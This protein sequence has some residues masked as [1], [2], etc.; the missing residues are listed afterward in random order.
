MSFRRIITGLVLSLGLIAACGIAA[1]A[2]VEGQGKGERHHDRVPLW[3]IIQQ[4]NLTDAQ[5]QQARA[6]VEKFQTNIEAQRQALT[7]L[8]RQKEQGTLS[9]DQRAQAQTLRGQ[10]DEARK[11]MQT[12]LFAILTPEQRT[13]YQELETRWKTRRDEMRTRRGRRETQ[14]D[15]Q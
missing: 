9:D 4:L 3:R 12:D 5:E 11:L 14:Q 7:D 10:I 6:V 15:Q 13:Q 2:Q 1:Y 8:H